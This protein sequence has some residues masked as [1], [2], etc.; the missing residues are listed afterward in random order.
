MAHPVLST[1]SSTLSSAPTEA[2]LFRDV[3][4]SLAQYSPEHENDK[5][6]LVLE[7]FL[8]QLPQEGSDNLR[9]DIKDCNSDEDLRGLANNLIFHILAPCTC[10]S[11]S[12]EILRHLAGSDLS[13][14]SKS[15]VTHSVNR[16]L[17]PSRLAGQCGIRRSGDQLESERTIVAAKKLSNT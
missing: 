6:R 16:T 13:L 15:E 8:S 5:T 10:L 14:Y 2:S 17:P 11:T 9:H 1:T 4:E 7:T 3:A 12:L